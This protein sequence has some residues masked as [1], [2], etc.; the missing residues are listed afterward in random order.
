MRQ[1]PNAPTFVE[2]RLVVVAPG[3]ETR[4]LIVETA[5]EARARDVLQAIGRELSID[6]SAAT[7]AGDRLP[8][9]APVSELGLRWGDELR[10]GATPAAPADITA[11]LVVD[12]GPEAGRRIPLAPGTYTVGRDADISIDDPSLSP[13]HI[14][15][16]AA[17]DGGPTVAHAGSRNG[18]VLDGMPLAPGTA[19]PLAP[20]TLV[21]AGRSLLGV[22]PPRRAPPPPAGTAGML[23][24]NRPPRV[25]RPPQARHRS[26]AAPPAE[27]Q[28]ARLPLAASL[29]PLA[30]GVGLYLLTN[31]VA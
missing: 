23:Y 19:V 1:P 5:P 15:L 4:D 13:N 29:I 28:R 18:T 30:L 31:L 14:V 17:A 12:G 22:A 20:G 6:A 16:T 21:R 26:F 11:E 3:G 2:L 25:R 27:P 8:G 10:L 7:V 24:V 9:D